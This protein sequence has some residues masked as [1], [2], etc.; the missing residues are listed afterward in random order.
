MVNGNGADRSIGNHVGRV[1]LTLAALFFAACSSSGSATNPATTTTGGTGNTT[2]GTG[3][4]PNPGG[5]V[6]SSNLGGMGQSLGGDGSGGAYSPGGAG[7]PTGPNQPCVP[8]ANVGP[9]LPA[10]F[11]T[12]CSAC[13][14]A[15]GQPA[16]PAVPNLFATAETEDLFLA[17]VRSGKKIMPPFPEAKMST[18]D[19]KKIY[20]YFKAGVP[21]SAP[22]C[23]PM[24]G[25]DVTPIGS[26]SMQTVSYARLFGDSTTTLEP[27]SKVDPTTKHIIYRGAGRVRFR[28]EMEDTFAIY[29]DHYFEGRTF[30]YTLDDS[31]PAG[32]K[33]TIVVNLFLSGN[34]FY[35]KQKNANQEGG[36][37]INFRAWKLYGHPDGNA[38]G[39]NAGGV[40]N[41]VLPF[42]CATDANAPTCDTK[43]YTYTLTRNDREG[44]DIMVGDQLQIEFGTFL[45]RYN[46]GDAMGPP[47]DTKHTR[48][49]MPIPQGCVLNGPPYNNK[50]YTQANYY[51]DSFRYTVGKGTL[52]PYNQ[53]CTMGV[54][55][56]EEGKYGD[57]CGPT[58][59]YGKAVAA[60]TL[61]DRIG[62]DEA[63]WSGG[64]ATMSYI[65]QRH[66]LY[67]S[68]MVPN[69]LQENAENFVQGRRLFHTDYTTG[70][71][72]EANNGITDAEAA[73]HKGF[74][75][76][77]MNQL[78]CEGC[79]SH[80]NRGFPPAAGQP[81]DSMVVRVY[82][83]GKDAD[84]APMPDANYGRQ[85]QP[86]AI[87]GAAEGNATFSFVDVPG[88]FG[89]GTAYTLTKP[90][91]VFTGMSAGAPTSYSTR[92][93]RPLIGMGLLEAIPEAD[94]LAHAD[95]T[96]CDKDGISG[97]P[98]I[99]FDP[100]DKK[101][102]LGRFGWKA[103]KASVR[104]QVTEA[105]NF[106]LGV[107]SS[108]FP[109]HE[110]GANQASCLAAD[111]ATPELSETDVNMLV[112][113]IRDLAVVPRRDLK[114]AQVMQGESLFSSLGCVNCHSPNQ[115]TG[116]TSP[117]L[118]MRDQ[119]IHPYSDLLLHD[120]GPELTDTTGQ[121]EFVAQPNEW[122]TPPLWGIG[123]CDEVALGFQK[124]VTLNPAPNLGPCHYLHDGRAAK[125]IDAVLWHGGEAQSVRDKVV[126]L[127]AADR[128]ALVAF[129]KS[130]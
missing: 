71:H 40:A 8:A 62:P 101:M 106:D 41:N 10:A 129:L 30:G 119:V 118:E 109:K 36:S 117:F 85:L 51:S 92:E 1:G 37:D 27:I 69:I 21:S 94:I 9:A 87:T 126:A 122:R 127:P 29:H 123:L 110:C 63:G 58:S 68:Q 49:I 70:Q 7:A 31:S 65:R 67:Y 104:H 96:D 45:A 42:N 78:T 4:N 57:G 89:D 43:H 61:A 44:R 34:H 79:H 100:E 90:T 46:N 39:A 28:H 66:D 115:H 23:Q 47:M 108:V 14:S 19:V 11:F 99:V 73:V 24:N 130:L 75:G 83:T 72:I 121:A 76:P 54:P 3:N 15:Y 128:D 53:D 102:H 2:G 116:N 124:D 56:G 35:S 77:L 93:A 32:G 111:K 114:N 98:N 13:H 74:A 82:G 113:Y 50:C 64:T 86:K 120:M 84:G 97:V 60:G 81:F 52:T 17:S 12:T 91:T 6:N 48:N 112:T 59:A 95:P 5:G 25:I 38:F 103:A 55:V 22:T 125:L 18:D 80:N 33:P 107:T 26:C 105:A 20:A 16:N 88:K